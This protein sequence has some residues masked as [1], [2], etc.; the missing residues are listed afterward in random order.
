MKTKYSLTAEHKAQLPQWEAKWRASVMSTA[1]MTET[2]RLICIDAVNGLYA[3]AD[4][5]LPK[6]I[7]FVPSPVV[8]RFAGGFASAIWHLSKKKGATEA[9]TRAATEDATRIAIRIATQAAT[10]DAT[11]A[12]TRIATRI[13]TQAATWHATEDA[14]WAATQAATRDATR[15]ATE[16]AIEAATQAATRAATEDATWRATNDA[17]EDAT[18]AATW[19]A[20]EAATQTATWDATEAGTRDATESATEAATWR[21]TE[22][23]TWR[24][25]NDATQAATRDATWDA[26]EAGTRRITSTWYRFAMKPQQIAAAMHLNKFGLECAYGTYKMHQGGN[27]WGAYDGY[28]SFFCHIAQLDIDYSKWRHWETLSLHSGPR[29]MHPDFC[30]ISDR[31]AV[32][33]V[34]DQNRPHCESG[35]FCQWRDGSSLYSVHGVRLPWDIIELPES[36]TVA[37]I[38]AEGNAEIRRIMTANFGEAR[39]IEESGLLPTH[40]DDFGELYRKTQPGDEDLVMVRVQNP[41]QL[42]GSQEHYWLRVTPTVR[43]ALEAVASTYQMSSAEYAQRLAVRT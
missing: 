31:P 40:R 43:T 25:T 20:T 24:A 14:T 9:A 15:I 11:Q 21:A 42:D 12:A 39:Y 28:L 22:A 2:D 37:R 35:P 38:N 5:P 33:M 27:Q 29:I 19:A 18:R 6:H 30:M 36:I 34:D 23:A 3:A 17:T 8:L 1:A 16:D 7:V 41:V 26:T 13:A 4:L 32:L 10:W